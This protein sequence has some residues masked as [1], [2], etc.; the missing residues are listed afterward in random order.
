ME[1][2]YIDLY[3]TI[4]FIMDFLLLYLVGICRKKKKAI[5]RLVSGALIGAFGACISVAFCCSRLES[6]ILFLIIG[7]AMNLAAFGRMQVGF[8]RN[9]ISLFLLVFCLGGFLYSICPYVYQLSIESSVI[10]YSSAGLALATVVFC[11]IIFVLRFR[12]TESKKTLIYPVS[13][14]LNSQQVKCNGLFDTGNSLYDAVFG[15]PVVLAVEEG[16][17]AKI[18]EEMKLHPEKTCMVMYSSVGKT[19]GMML[20]IRI[21]EMVIKVQQ[22][23]IKAGNMVIAPVEYRKKQE[24][25]QIIL[26]PDFM[27]D[28]W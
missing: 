2:V 27:P 10:Y 17:C 11:L 19:D 25:Y 6:V 23:D 8:A 5:L 15:L 24:L 28:E 18:K 22:E 21:D 13:I 1:E 9:Q 12:R 16:L 4:N 20:G 26:H 14:N 3:F 7:T